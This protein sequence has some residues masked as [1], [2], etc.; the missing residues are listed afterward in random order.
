MGVDKATVFIWAGWAGLGA[1]GV[2]IAGSLATAS[3][4]VTAIAAL[5]AIACGGI[6]LFTRKVDEYTRGLWNAGASMAFATLLILY[7]GLPFAEG[8]YDGAR[9][10]EKT[11]DIPARLS[12]MTAIGMF[13]VGAFWKRFR[14]DA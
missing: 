8:V 5:I 7:L 14:G 12:V 1:M 10:A 9:G 13:F 11:Q 3:Q 6:M 4:T 2:L